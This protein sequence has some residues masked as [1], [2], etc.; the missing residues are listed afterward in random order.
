[1]V[2]CFAGFFAN[3][4]RVRGDMKRGEKLHSIGGRGR[5]GE[6]EKSYGNNSNNQFPIVMAQMGESEL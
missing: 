3:I 1:M 4:F 5:R 6:F 2:C